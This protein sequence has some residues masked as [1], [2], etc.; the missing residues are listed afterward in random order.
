MIMLEVLNARERD[1]EDYQ[2]LFAEVDSRFKYQGC[3]RLEGYRMGVVEAIW[4]P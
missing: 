1:E 4:E 3:R 2:Q